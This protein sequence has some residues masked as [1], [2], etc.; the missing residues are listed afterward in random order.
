MN[1]AQSLRSLS[2][3]PVPSATLYDI[4]E[5]L[6]LSADAELTPEARQSREFRLA[7]AK[8]YIFLSEAPDVTQNGVSFSFTDDDRKR[9]RSRGEAMLEEMGDSPAFGADYGYQGE[10]L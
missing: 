1:V 5:G 6:G 7:Q 9:L 8:V 3:Y 10:D 4:A 2:A